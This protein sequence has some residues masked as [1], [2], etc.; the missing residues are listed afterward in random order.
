VGSFFT[1]LERAVS[2]H[3]DVGWDSKCLF[4]L[5]RHGHSRQFI[6]H[7]KSK[8]GSVVHTLITFVP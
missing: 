3:N 1:T 5:N 6:C 7:G 2:P 4:T 8:N